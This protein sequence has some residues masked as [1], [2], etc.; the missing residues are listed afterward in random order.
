MASLTPPRPL[1]LALSVAVG[2]AVALAV[3]LPDVRSSDVAQ[4]LAVR[5]G[6]LFSSA[7]VGAALPAVALH[8][9]LMGAHFAHQVKQRQSQWLR[10]AFATFAGFAAATLLASAVGALLAVALQG[11]V[12]QSAVL[13]AAWSYPTDASVVFVCP[14]N[15]TN[16]SVALQSDGTLACSANA[17]TFVLDDVARTFVVEVAAANRAASVA[18]QFA[19]VLNSVFPIS[20]AGAFL[21]GDVL[22]LLIVGIVVGVALVCFVSKQDDVLEQDEGGNQSQEEKEDGRL[23]LLELVAQT[24]AVTCAILRWLQRRLPIGAAFMMSSVLL[25]SSST[26][27]GDVNSM[28]ATALAFVAVLLLALVLDVVVMMALAAL[29]TRSNPFAFLKHLVSA[30]LLALSS[31]ST[32][33]ALPATVA[34]VAS[35]NRVSSPLAFIVCA[36]GTVLNQ[37]GSALYLSV[38][39]LFVLTASASGMSSDELTAVEAPGNNVAMVFANALIAS[40]LSPLPAGVKTV[41]LATTLGAIFGVTAGPRA[42]LLAFMA[43]LEWITNPLVACVNVTN[44]ALVAFVMAHYLDE[45]RAAETVGGP[46]GSGAPTQEPTPDRQERRQQR[47]MTMANSQVVL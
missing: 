42:V 40:V 45:K 6:E 7:F 11:I 18:E 15:V 39:T 35:S 41:A 21:A 37:T 25:R 30:Q 2:V 5:P 20:A 36:T 4:W 28:A 23:V 32:L 29:L 9:V 22:G 19:V 14:S 8:A 46:D 10:L 17:T 16:G 27:E 1:L 44:N 12:P 24:E 26:D 13:G 31:A 33:V 47:A 3:S 43:A 34:T 38:A